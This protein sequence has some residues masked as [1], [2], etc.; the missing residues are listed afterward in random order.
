M[1]YVQFRFVAT[2]L[3]LFSANTCLVANTDAFL[4]GA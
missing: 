1:Q 4:F 2:V 3:L